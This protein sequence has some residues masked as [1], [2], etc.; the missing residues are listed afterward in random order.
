[1]RAEVFQQ[2]AFTIRGRGAQAVDSLKGGKKLGYWKESLLDGF[3]N[4][5]IKRTA[6][7]IA[8]D[9]VSASTS[10]NANPMF[11]FANGPNN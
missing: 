6:Q 5:P 1:M 8:T 3:N 7:Q 9:S 11:S 10:M 2:R 4:G